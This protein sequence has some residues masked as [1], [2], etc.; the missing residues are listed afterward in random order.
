MRLIVNHAT[1]SRHANP[2]RRRVATAAAAG[3]YDGGTP[4]RTG[5]V[6]RSCVGTTY[7]SALASSEGLFPNQILT[8]YGIAQL[9]ASGL[10][11][12]GAG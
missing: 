9:Q 12:Q 1:S 11:G 8:A 4:T 10:R 5:T 3:P 2:P 7:P 6:G